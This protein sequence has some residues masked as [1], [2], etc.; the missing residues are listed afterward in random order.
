MS[1]ILEQVR[2]RRLRHDLAAGLQHVDAVRERGH[3]L[4]V[5]RGDHERH[6]VVAVQA[7]QQLDHLAARRRVQPLE[8][9]IEYEQLGLQDERAGERH[10]ALLAAREVVTHLVLQVRDAHARH[11][12]RHLAVHLGGRIAVVARAERNVVPHRGRDDLRVGVLEQH[13][14]ALADLREL[15]R[16]V[17]AEHAHLAL[18]GRQQAEDV[19][20][21]RALPAAVRA[22]HHDPLSPAD[23]EVEAA[24]VDTGLVRIRVPHARYV[25]DRLAAVQLGMLVAHVALTC[26]SVTLTTPAQA[27]ARHTQKSSRENSR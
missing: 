25:H 24:E 12:R 9:F 26:Q 14:D 27:I 3:E 8:R 15:P 18:L 6:A 1:R 2:G 19:V 20:E 5:V 21:E 7:V 10:L 4:D 13:A 16:R 17:D 11:R 23:H 22:Q